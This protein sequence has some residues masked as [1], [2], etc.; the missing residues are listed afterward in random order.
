MHQLRDRILDF[1]FNDCILIF[2]DLPQ[3]D[4]DRCV[5]NSVKFFCATP[6]SI[7]KR[8]LWPLDKLKQYS[9]L[10]RIELDDLLKMLEKSNEIYEE[11]V[12]LNQA[13]S[14]NHFVFVDCRS[15]DDI[16]HFGAIANSVKFEEFSSGLNQDFQVRHVFKSKGQQPLPQQHQQFKHHL[17]IVVNSAD[18]AMT[19][20]EN[21]IVPRVC[22]LELNKFVPK[23]LRA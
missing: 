12:I 23:L 16:A 7:T 5:R 4:I 2:S 10:P 11:N 20:I 14:S 15:N 22:Y 6:Q 21:Y 19:L 9:R 1:T 3:I 18:K 13:Q 8:G 17:V